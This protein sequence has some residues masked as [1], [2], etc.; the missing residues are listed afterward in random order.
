MELVVHIDLSKWKEAL[1]ILSTYGKSEEFPAMCE[2]LAA[3]LEAEANDIASATL[4]YMCAANVTRTVSFWVDELTATNTAKGHVDTIA[5]QEFVEK[6]VV[7]T[8][9]NPGEALGDQCSVYFAEYANLLASQGKLEVAPRYLKGEHIDEQVLRDRLYHAG[10][11]KP[12]GSR[13]P[14]FPFEKVLVSPAPQA[15]QGAAQGQAPLPG[16]AQPAAQ[17][18]AAAFNASPARPATGSQASRGHVSATT[19]GQSQSAATATKLAP[20]PTPSTAPALPPGW[21]QLIDPAS[22]RPYY[23]DQAT[24]ASQW[25]PPQPAIPTASSAAS[26]P[27]PLPSPAQ[28]QAQGQPAASAGG[29]MGGISHPSS[30]KTPSFDDQHGAAAPVAIAAKAASPTHHVANTQPAESA[31]APSGSGSQN[32]DSLQLIFDSLQGKTL[33]CSEPVTEQY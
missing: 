29:G 10:T 1:A 25:E 33:K 24:G 28:A 16:R 30:L 3:R 6:V 18:S 5:L 14:P 31:G 17:D 12:V 21:L 2:A 22:N 32:F 19:T 7:Y 20:S 4:C 9:A 23:V 13:P 15:R 27:M 11:S 8:H 26:V